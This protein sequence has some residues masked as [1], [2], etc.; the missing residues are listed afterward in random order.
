MELKTSLVKRIEAL[1]KQGG[2]GADYV[3]ITYENGYTEMLTRA[4]LA[5]R[6]REIT[7][8]LRDAVNGGPRK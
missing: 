7:E 5:E 2:I 4:E 6:D 8:W 3:T 1:E